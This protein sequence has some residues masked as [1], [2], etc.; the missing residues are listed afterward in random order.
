MSIMLIEN[1]EG[2]WCN[3]KTM[4]LISSGAPRDSHTHIPVLVPISTILHSLVY[5]SLE[6][7]IAA[8]LVKYQS[9]AV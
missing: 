4:I 7:P 8:A 3:L 9:N 5:A 1:A 2:H 6:G